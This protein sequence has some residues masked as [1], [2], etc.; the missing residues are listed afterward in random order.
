[1]EIFE[2]DI[3]RA[4]KG[5]VILNSEIYRRDVSYGNQQYKAAV[6]H[7]GDHENFLRKGKYCIFLGKKTE[8][9]ALKIFVYPHHHKL[10]RTTMFGN[11]PIRFLPLERVQRI[12]RIHNVLQSYNLAPKC[13]RIISCRVKKQIVYG[14]EMESLV[15]VDENDDLNSIKEWRQFAAKLEDICRKHK[16][17]RRGSVESIMYDA[18]LSKNY[19]VTEDGIK[20]IDIDLKWNILRAR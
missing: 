5:S 6:Y 16:L 13:N 19:V 10:R 4:D 2:L 11:R 12:I 9:L 1:M 14:I 20:L 15:Q 18:S 7:H 17:V 3:A 8:P